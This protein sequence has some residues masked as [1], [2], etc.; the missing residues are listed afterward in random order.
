M[1][2]A[3][4][5]TGGFFPF[6]LPVMCI[7]CYSWKGLMSLLSDIV[8]NEVLVPDLRKRMR[9]DLDKESTKQHN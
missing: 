1:R 5:I 6:S 9:N 8:L 4:Y 3:C 2:G 7:V